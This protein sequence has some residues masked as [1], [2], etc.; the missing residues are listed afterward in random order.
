MCYNPDSRVL[1]RYLA[2]DREAVIGGRVVQYEYSYVNAFLAEGR[3]QARLQITAVVVYGD[4]D[5]YGGA[6]L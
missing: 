3:S 4:D 2:S 1:I 6:A 5:T